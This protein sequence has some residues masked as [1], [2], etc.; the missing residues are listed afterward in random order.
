MHS[1][2]NVKNILVINNTFDITLF[3]VVKYILMGLFLRPEIE[4]NK[5]QRER[6]RQRERERETTQKLHSKKDCRHL[7]RKRLCFFFLFRNII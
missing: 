5:L 6:D 4:K 1:C 3:T 7:L 2:E